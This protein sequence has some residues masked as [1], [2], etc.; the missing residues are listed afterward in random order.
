MTVKKDEEADLC[1]CGHA[2][3]AHKES[4]TVPG[5]SCEGMSRAGDDDADVDTDDDD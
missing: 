5:C 2:E 3:R 1:V 4:C